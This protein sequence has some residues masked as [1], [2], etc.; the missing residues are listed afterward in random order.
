MR[1]R[2]IAIAL[3]VALVGGAAAAPARAAARLV[4]GPIATAEGGEPGLAARLRDAVAADPSFALI[5]PT[6]EAAAAEGAVP[7]RAD[8]DRVRAWSRAAGGAP[9]LV[10]EV[11]AGGA[12]L[13][14]RSGHSGG[15]AEAWDVPSGSGAAEIERVL[16]SVRNAVLEME[17]PAVG[18]GPPETVED[19][20]GR[21]TLRRDEPISIRS[22][23]LDVISQEGRRHLVFR[24]RVVVR[25]GDI[26]LRTERLDAFYAPGDSQPE[27]LVARGKVEVVQGDRVAHCD[28]AVYVRA[29]D[30]VV[31]SGRAELVQ[32]CD[33]VR[34]ERLEFDLEREHFRVTG[35]ASVE[36]GGEGAA[37][38]PAGADA[39]HAS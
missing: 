16:A 30:T 3:A 10:G 18:T 14:L 37:C 19:A 8:A 27:R 11:G 15:V 26:E 22:E 31:C 33:V 17:G 29:D 1:R 35:A 7:P 23:Q 36:L 2:G 24:D 12:R 20:A 39:E 34:G 21:A 25:Q 38:P 6:G 5:A 9:V 28:E 13:E 32:G 4:L